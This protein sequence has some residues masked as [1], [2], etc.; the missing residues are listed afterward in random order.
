MGQI[1]LSYRSLEAEFALK[2]AADLKNSGVRIWVD[3]LDGIG[4]GDDWRVT[5][6]QAINTCA[7]LIPVLSPGYVDSAYCRNELARADDLKRP[8]FP[9]LLQAVPPG[10]WPL[11]VQRLQYEDFTGWRDEAVY[12]ARCKALVRRLRAE[13]RDQVGAPPDAETRY[14]TKLI[15]DLEAKRGVIQY[16]ELTVDAEATADCRPAP[17]PEEDEWGFIWLSSTSSAAIPGGPDA[18][19]SAPTWERLAGMAEAVEQL[20]RFVLVGEPGAG[21]TTAL[22]RLVR[23]AA[24][25]R[26]KNPI[27]APLPLWID[28][29]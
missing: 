25:R 5:I 11:V 6:E 8:I 14:L 18:P 16:V 22:R 4:V 9:I 29:L 19:T 17:R 1:F 20:P 2:L 3:R 28:L 12:R 7:A 15:A 10:N 27:A 26:L 24:R 21:K 23:D 13:A